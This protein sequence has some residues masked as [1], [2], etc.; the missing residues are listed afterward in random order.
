M[1]NRILNKRLCLLCAFSALTPFG[2]MAQ[3]CNAPY[4]MVTTLFHP[5]PGAYSVW[6]TSYGEPIMDETFSSVLPLPDGGAIAV[7]TWKETKAAK[8]QLLIVEFDKRGRKMWSKTHKIDGLMNV[9]KMI[10]DQDGYAIAINIKGAKSGKGIYLGFLDRAGQVKNSVILSEAKFGLSAKDFIRAADGKNFVMAVAREQNIGTQKSPIMQNDAGI[11]ILN[12]KGIKSSERFYILG[13]GSEIK[14]LSVSKFDKNE[15]GYIATGWFVNDYKKR[16]GWVLRLR[17]DASLV[18]Q[19]EFER[20]LAASV[21]VS[22]A[23]NSDSILVFGEVLPADSGSIGSMLMMLNSI[24]G[25]IGWQRYYKGET[26]NHDYRPR[27]IVVNKDGL[28][29]VAMQAKTEANAK[30]LAKAEIIDAPKSDDEAAKDGQTSLMSG[31][32]H[33]PDFMDYVHVLTLTPRGI[34]ISGDSYFEGKG[35]MIA[36]MVLTPK[37]ERL[38]V[39]TA[40]V[41]DGD[42]ATAIQASKGASQPDT[43]AEPAGGEVKPN[44]PQVALPENTMKGLAMLG[45]KIEAATAPLNK[46]DSGESK[47]SDKPAIADI[48]SAEIDGVN[49]NGWI[50]TGAAPDTY[51]DPCIVKL[52]TLNAQ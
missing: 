14:N 6:D 8:P 21:E 33:V 42:I 26:G 32:L 39:G 2:A 25:S 9:V 1:L 27:S 29:L 24:D 11:F 22:S 3:Q 37:G 28:I 20:G 44:L 19:R 5:D 46:P 15:L 48:K 49:E 52:K 13:R 4:E 50:V 43:P 7:G 45:K 31:D 41:P 12:T 17:E 38:M 18:W 47:E 51:T 34:T 36:Q 35:G 40:N 10:Q 30:A 16:I 23:Y